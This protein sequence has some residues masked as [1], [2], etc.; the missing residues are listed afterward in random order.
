MGTLTD[1]TATDAAAVHPGLP[2]DAGRGRSTRCSSCPTTR[3]RAR[4][5]GMTT[6][7]AGLVR[8]DADP[9]PDRRPARRGRAGRG[10]P[11][12]TPAARV[13]PAGAGPLHARRGARAGDRVRAR[14]RLP[15]GHARGVRPTLR[16]WRPAPFARLV[17]AGLR[18]RVVDYRLSGE[19]VFPAPARRRPGRGP[20]AAHPRRRAR[21]RPDPDRRWGRVGGRPP[22]HDARAHRPGVAGVVDWYG[23]A[24]L[25]TMAAQARPDAIARSDAPD[26]RESQLI[27]A[28]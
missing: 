4:G 7:H 14:R 22:R 21:R 17:A 18:R 24:D 26:S 11:S 1:H 10:A 15:A 2:A 28:R 13:P 19:A 12:P 3:G 27:G 16:D 9:L 6:R 25:T 5:A 23:P 20:L 8:P